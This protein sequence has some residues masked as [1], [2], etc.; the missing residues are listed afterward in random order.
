MHMHSRILIAALLVV[1]MLGLAQEPAG[2][3]T[4][5]PAHKAA[6]QDVSSPAR[7]TFDLKDA[8]MQSVIRA[9]AATASDGFRL[10]SSAEQ[11]QPQDNDTAPARAALRSIPFRAP[12]RLH[13]M[14]CDSLNCVAY[15]ADGEALYSVPREQ[16]FGINTD[17]SKEAWLSCQ[18]SDN[19]LTTFE[20]YDKC[21]GVSIGLPLQSH[22]VIVNLPKIRL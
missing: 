10:S 6:A 20:R 14:D 18:S 15:S 5:E 21:R 22:D 3:K 13:H 7:P 2:V 19:L 1:P 17:D 16:Q 4:A 11:R 9:S 8:A 12:R